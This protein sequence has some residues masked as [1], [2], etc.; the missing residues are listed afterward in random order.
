MPVFA[1]YSW[2][3][4]LGSLRFLTRRDIHL[5]TEHLLN[6]TIC[7]L[8]TIP[9]GKTSEWSSPLGSLGRNEPAMDGKGLGARRGPG[10]K[11]SGSLRRMS[12]SLQHASLKGSISGSQKV[13]WSF[14]PGSK[15]SPRAGEEGGGLKALFEGQQLNGGGSSLPA[16]GFCDSFSARYTAEGYIPS[17]LTIP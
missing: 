11:L 4:W 1:S 3:T 9:T 2:F 10:G 5:G 6:F 16:L 17:Y 15:K 8:W 14:W 13:S 12:S 7:W